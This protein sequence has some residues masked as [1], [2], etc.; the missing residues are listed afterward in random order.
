MKI[1]INKLNILQYVMIVLNG[2]EAEIFDLPQD[3]KTERM[4]SP[5]LSISKMTGEFSKEKLLYVISLNTDFPI[6]SFIRSLHETSIN[7]VLISHQ[8][9]LESTI[10]EYRMKNIFIHLND[11][12]EI[13]SLI[14]DSI[15][16]SLSQYDKDPW[17]PVENATALRKL[18]SYCVKQDEKIIDAMNTKNFTSCDFELLISNAELNG[19]VKLTD[20]V[21]ESIKGFAMLSTI[22]NSI[23]YVIFMLPNL[24]GNDEQLM[25]LFRFFWRF[26]R[27]LRTVICAEYNCFKYDPFK[28]V[29]LHTD[30]RSGHYFPLVS[31]QGG[32]FKTGFVQKNELYRHTN[33]AGMTPFIA[34]VGVIDYLREKLNVEIE[35]DV[36]DMWGRFDKDEKYYEIAL[37]SN[38]DAIIFQDSICPDETV[39]T[40]FDFSAAIQTCSQCFSVPRSAFI[41]PCLLPFKSFS[42]QVWAA[43]ITTILLLYIAM[44]LFYYSQRT[45]FKQLYT[46]ESLR[47]FQNTSVTFILCAFFLVGCPWRLLLGRVITG[48]ILFTILS[49]F[50]LIIVTVFQSQ[51]T[52]LLATF[53][54]YPDIDTLKDLID[55]DLSIQTFN[56]DISS[57]LLEEH[58][59]SLEKLSESF[60]FYERLWASF[61]SYTD[62]EHNRSL[63]LH[64]Q[65]YMDDTYMDDETVDSL[66]LKK[67]RIVKSNMNAIMELDAF[68][69]SVPNMNQKDHG[70]FKAS[71]HFGRRMIELHL[72]KECFL[73]YAMTLRSP[74]NFL[75]DIIFDRIN[76]FV[77]FGLLDIEERSM[78]WL[79]K[80]DQT[81]RDEST[82]A[83]A[84][85]LTMQNLQPAFVSLVLGWILSFVVFAIELAIDVCQTTEPS[86]RD[87]LPVSN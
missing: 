26:F 63:E 43:I 8:T 87:S 46:E 44:C 55:S 18:S 65:E 4:L 3:K 47:E 21:F 75:S 82:S 48:K 60:V 76:S 41:P 2:A 62:D 72:V 86:N 19:D 70:N 74:K 34:V 40:Q 81:L 16:H 59:A 5:A 77:E 73:T 37:R 45:L 17:L 11:M 25:F 32:K 20:S 33:S 69:V 1:L 79:V 83:E 85:G 31:M 36:F 66:L 49:L 68:E 39:F 42:L 58:N 22:W 50:V 71:S 15:P 35:Y 23:N 78:R 13:L 27:G 12:N 28:S 64:L 10:T 67:V 30:T 6:Q 52:T 84:Q 24:D 9:W 57:Y 56:V 61:W 14:L 80:W 29:I 54:R 7:T 38:I 51:L 53:V